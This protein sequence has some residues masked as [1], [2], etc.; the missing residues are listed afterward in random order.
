[1]A[2]HHHLPLALLSL[3]L[4]LACSLPQPA[5][6]APCP[7]FTCGEGQFTLGKFIDP[8]SDPLDDYS[9]PPEPVVEAYFTAGQMYNYNQYN[10]TDETISDPEP[11]APH[12]HLPLA[13]LS[14]SLLLA[15][16]L[17]QPASAAPCPKFTCGEGQFTLGKF[18][19][20][21]SDPLDDYSEPPEP[22]VE[23]YFTAGQ[24][25]NYNQYNITDE[26]ISDPPR[27]CYRL[28][29]GYNA[30]RKPSETEVKYWMFEETCLESNGGTCTCYAKSQCDS[31]NAYSDHWDQGPK[32]SSAGGGDYQVAANFSVGELCD[33]GH[34][35]D[36][37]FTGADGSHYD[38]S[39]RPNRNYAIVSDLH[40]QVN[41]YFGGRYAR[42]GNRIKSL[43]WIRSV[44]IMFGHHTAVLDARTG[45]DAE[46]DTDGYLAKVTADG[47]VLELKAPGTVVTL[48]DG[49]T[50]KWV[51]GRQRSGD[52]YVDV[53]DVTIAGVV[54]LR[55]TLRPEV[56]SLRTPRD[57]TVHFGLNV[58]ESEFSPAVHGILGQTYRNEFAGRLAHQKLEWS[59]LLQTMVVPGDN[60]EG[61]I[62]GSVDEY[63]VTGLLKSDC[64][65]C[66]FSRAE[67]VDPE[68]RVALSLLGGGVSGG[69]LPAT[70]PKSAIQSLQS[71][72]GANA[73]NAAG[74]ATSTDD[75]QAVVASS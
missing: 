40:L 37:H 6:A 72:R 13:L 56:E 15:C 68:T 71:L 32:G 75:R 25:Y 69:G 22:V 58:L 4:L 63:E 62:D 1:M 5:S 57:G 27:D 43:T 61:F 14:L 39:G 17:P 41:G 74:A 48:W 38:F 36:P 44:G 54:T 50:L 65:L 9:E 24:M 12:H 51:A 23:A 29:A 18:I 55:M 11:M 10:I 45:P 2:P 47:K 73:A 7:K 52:D 31:P 33:P 19:D 66:Q 26:T 20:P 46:Y 8:N 67:S 34:K 42:W 64:T 21:N 53:F 49:A 70:M 3:S 16:S 28:C 30:N 59:S 60:A 35:G